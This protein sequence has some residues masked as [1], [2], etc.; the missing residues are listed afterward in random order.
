MTELLRANLVAHLTFYRRSRLLLAFL[1]L[2]AV[3]TT[4]ATVP[5]FFVDSGVQNFNKLH[6]ILRNHQF[7]LKPFAAGLGLFM[8][9]ST[10]AAAVQSPLL[11]EI[12]NPSE[13]AEADSLLLN[14]HSRGHSRK[15]S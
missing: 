8:C 11:L 3:L 6:E 12:P 9:R 10:F 4:L 13:I 2:F 14:W 1:I 5:Q 15:S 7:L